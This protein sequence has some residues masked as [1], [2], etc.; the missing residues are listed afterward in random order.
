MFS[1]FS[2]NLS[3]PGHLQFDITDQINPYSIYINNVYSGKDHFPS[4]GVRNNQ[5]SHGNI[6]YLF[7]ATST[8]HFHS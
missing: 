7:T 3:D 4:R 6:L 8:A 2:V 5:E 1:N